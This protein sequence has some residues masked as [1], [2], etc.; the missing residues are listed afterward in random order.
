MLLES[1]KKA[2]A[3]G[4][5]VGV[6]FQRRHDARYKETIKRML[7]GF[8]VMILEVRSQESRVK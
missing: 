4:L 3:K 1:N 7:L 5:K 8:L 2:K 6:G